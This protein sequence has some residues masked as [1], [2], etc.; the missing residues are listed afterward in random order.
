MQDSTPYRLVLCTCPDM[1]T[2]KDLA[3]RL[4]ASR[5]AA[6]VNI[7][8]GLTS[9]YEWKGAVETESELLLLA[10]TTQKRYPALESTLRAAHP[11]ELPEIICVPIVAGLSGYIE[12]IENSTSSS[13]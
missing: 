13:D 8:P 1:G 6:C 11:Y 5:L 3:K 12:W 4:V 10:K 9:V 7:L 2:A